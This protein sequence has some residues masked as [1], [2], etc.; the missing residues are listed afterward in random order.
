MML[1][2]GMALKRWKKLRIS[3]LRLGVCLKLLVDLAECRLKRALMVAAGFLLRGS[4]SCHSLALQTAWLNLR[5]NV[6]VVGLR[7]LRRRWERRG[8]R[9]GPL[10]CCQCSLIVLG[11]LRGRGR[12]DG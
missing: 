7:G 11:R 2:C 3:F 8:W 1:F 5:R 6:V 10:W 4:A 9:V 12:G